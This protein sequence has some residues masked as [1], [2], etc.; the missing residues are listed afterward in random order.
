MLTG[1]VCLREDIA[2]REVRRPSEWTFQKSLDAMT[3]GETVWSRAMD[4]FDGID[5]LGI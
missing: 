5:V 1:D 2:I 3:A 4:R